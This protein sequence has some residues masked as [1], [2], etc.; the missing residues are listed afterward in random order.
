ML[1]C[2]AYTGYHGFS[3]LNTDNL[4]FTLSDVRLVGQS[5]GLTVRRA[6]QVKPSETLEIGFVNATCA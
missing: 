3:Y 2:M 5:V 1:L 6:G 4:H